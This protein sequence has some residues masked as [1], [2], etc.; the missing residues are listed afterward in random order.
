MV[1]EKMGN[2]RTE[3]LSSWGVRQDLEERA[4]VWVLLA[5]EGKVSIRG[6]ALRGKL[7]SISGCTSQRKQQKPPLSRSKHPSWSQRLLLE[8]KAFAWGGIVATPSDSATRDIYQGSSDRKSNQEQESSPQ[9]HSAKR[10]SSSPQG[11]HALDILPSRI[12]K[13]NTGEKLLISGKACGVSIWRR[14]GPCLWCC[15][16]MQSAEIKSQFHF[17]FPAS[18]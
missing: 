13:S 2:M 16:R 15:H 8:Q 12:N 11:K 14:L 4:G 1:G 5:Y 9:I 7:L 18:A 3:K 6:W 10:N 17:R